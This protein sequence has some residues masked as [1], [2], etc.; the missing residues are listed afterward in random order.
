MCNSSYKLK[1]FS[2]KL[3]YVFWFDIF[4]ATF[5]VNGYGTYTRVE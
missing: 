4:G 1:M 2:N 5:I 3:N